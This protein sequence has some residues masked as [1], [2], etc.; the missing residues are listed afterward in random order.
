MTRR[1]MEISVSNSGWGEARTIDI[2]VLLADVASHLNRLLVE[3]VVEHISVVPVCHPG[4]VPMTP[5]RHGAPGPI[6]IQ[7]T[8]RDRKWAKFSYQFAH[9]FCHVLSD[10]ERLGSNPNNWFHEALCELASVFT[11]RRMA[12]RWPTQPPYPH[13]TEYAGNLASYAEDLLTND[14][15]TLP[16]G[17]HLATWLSNEEC[18]LRKN[19]ELRGKNAIVAYQL[20]PLFEEDPS[21]WN[22]VHRMPSSTGILTEYLAD[23]HECV[24]PADKPFVKRVIGAFQ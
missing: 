11:L 1:G 13:W 10:Y 5:Y 23:W 12:E 19:A 3:P 20:L 21:G 18:E 4:A 17:V 22:A 16:E 8:A 7:L 9:E 24:Q 2:T 15:R 14:S 6:T